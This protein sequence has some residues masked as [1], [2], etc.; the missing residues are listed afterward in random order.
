MLSIYN[1]L[2][3][4]LCYRTYWKQWLAFLT[5]CLLVFACSSED[6]EDCSVEPSFTINEVENITGTSALI[7]AVII[8]PSCSEIESVTSQGFVYS[9]NTLPTINDNIV[10]KNGN[11]I[12][13]NLDDITPN[14]TYYVR[15]F[16]QN[17]SGEYYSE[18]V[19]FTTNGS[20]ELQAIL[21]I[22]ATEAVV[23]SQ[24]IGSNQNIIS[25]GVCWSTN[26]NPTVNDNIT[27]DTSVNGNYSSY[28]ENLSPSTEYFLRS[29]LTTDVG[30]VYSDE[31][32]FTTYSGNISFESFQMIYVAK[33][34]MWYDFQ[35]DPM[36][37]N[38]ELALH[39]DEY[40]VVYSLSENPNLDDNRIIHSTSNP[41]S[42]IQVMG[43]I[44]G[45]TM[46]TTYYAKAYAIDS[47]GE[48]TYSSQLEIK[49]APQ[50]LYSE[51]D[52]V[53][54]FYNESDNT[55]QFQVFIS[56]N[57][58]DI[59]Y[60]KNYQW[61][62]SNNSNF[63][64]YISQACNNYATNEPNGDVECSQYSESVLQITSAP[65]NSDWWAQ[66]G[67]TEGNEYFFRAEL[68]DYDNL[69]HFGSGPL[70]DGFKGFIC[71]YE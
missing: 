33:E 35:L 43:Q 16:W 60:V 63:S 59:I 31:I 24:I 66:L 21:N 50:N 52:N 30:T 67:I 17:N 34:N 23:L 70:T 25:S 28:L 14:E 47:T 22:Y 12:S 69:N 45:L 4:K 32:S 8:P 2:K 11:E 64:T 44:E 49:T 48:V 1:F 54:W 29:Y 20:V 68:F 13:H 10:V 6:S 71:N 37:V 27:D 9:V 56:M 58:E 51:I 39:I 19:V 46:N 57:P 3:V 5:M 18:Q 62:F 40:G 26:S 15:A 55:Y 36:G 61:N 65:F 41:T 53:L 38:N 42:S 7:S